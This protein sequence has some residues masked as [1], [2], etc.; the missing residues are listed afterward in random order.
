MDWQRSEFRL[1]N[2]WPMDARNEGTDDR[3][4]WNQKPRWP[5]LPW[6]RH[7]GT[8]PGGKTSSAVYF[9]APRDDTSNH[10]T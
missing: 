3:A 7:W 10:F 1:L 9:Y 6:S 4:A 2:K 5:V 8:V